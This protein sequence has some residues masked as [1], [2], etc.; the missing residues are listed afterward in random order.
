MLRDW[1]FDVFDD[2]FDHSYDK[3]DNNTRIDTLFKDNIEVITHGLTISEDIQK[4][5]IKNREY[6]FTKFYDVVDV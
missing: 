5:L 1:G 2:I 4:R 3:V 6:Y